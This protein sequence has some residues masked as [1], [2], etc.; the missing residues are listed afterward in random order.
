[1]KAP[2]I[3]ILIVF[4]IP[5]ISADTLI[6]YST[7]TPSNNITS[8]GLNSTL[9]IETFNI[10]F[11]LLNVSSTRIILFNLSYTNPASCGGVSSFYDNYSI[12]TINNITT[13]PSYCPN[14]TSIIPVNQTETIN[15]TINYTAEINSSIGLVNTTLNIENI[16]GSIINQTTSTF[17]GDV[18][19]FMIG[20]TVT[21]N[22][23]VYN[24]WYAFVDK[25]M[26]IITGK[27]RKIT[28][29]I[30]PPTITLT[31]PQY[32]NY[33]DNNS[34]PFAFNVTDNLIGVKDC[35]YTI[36]NSTGI[37]IPSTSLPSCQN[38]TIKLPEGDENYIL[39]L[40]SRDKLDNTASELAYFGVRTSSPAIV[41]RVEN[42]TNTNNGNNI[43]LNFS[44]TTNAD[45]IP[46]CSLW[47][48]FGG[49]FSQ[50]QTIF[51]G[52]NGKTVN[53]NPINLSE[54][55]HLWNV[56]CTDNLGKVGWAL[57]N[58]TF[59]VDFTNP[60]ISN[61]SITT[62][63]GFQTFNFS[64]IA[65][66]L[67]LNNCRYTIYTADGLID[68]ISSNISF[69]CSLGATATA[70]GFGTYNL[71]V[72]AYDYAGNLNRTSSNFTLTGTLSPTGGGGATQTNLVP[73]VTLISPEEDN[74]RSVIDR[75][76][77]Y[78]VIS[79]YCSK[80]T[81]FGKC[82]TN[83]EV[84]RGIIVLLENTYR[85]RMTENKLPFW[86]S[87]YDSQKFEDVNIDK[88]EAER[89]DLVISTIIQA[90]FRISPRRVDPF[91]KLVLR[92]DKVNI[93][94]TTSNRK[95]KSCD[96]IEGDLGFSC[97]PS[98]TFARVVYTISE[99]ATWTSR[100]PFAKI[101]YTDID[102]N[103]DFQD[104]TARIIKGTPQFYAYLIGISLATFFLI[105]FRKKIS[106]FLKDIYKKVRKTF[107]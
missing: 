4:L 57:S 7:I 106:K 91:I 81:Q 79:E 33:G 68:G 62:T 104:L 65:E 44:A 28:I 11:D 30:T 48:D 43:I 60:N 77:L 8:Y 73:V 74:L 87:Q 93:I 100:V 55:N 27:K 107:R 31:D 41:L 75:A 2:I 97:I 47:G 53:F 82:R 40:T 1:M 102:G 25:A 52:W 98:D 6:Y 85:L 69:D 17:A 19:F 70:T 36:Y 34:I 92:G 76:K 18:F 64:V 50:N 5:L 38:T 42:Y 24:W 12:T 99:N 89:W 15:Q 71:S 66:D 16:I 101:S 32:Q 37:F 14:I 13:L 46:V 22:E 84:S 3:F 35:N 29:D 83:S 45:N 95:L 67:N 72:T 56:N 21:L 23:G 26:N 80:N 88:R 39:L 58:N 20:T 90:E 105:K 78:K 86:F 63:E 54:G 59:A 94:T 9:K 49:T 61:L 51:Y 96:V 10:S 103:N